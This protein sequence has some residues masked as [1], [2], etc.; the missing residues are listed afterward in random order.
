MHDSAFSQ[1]RDFILFNTT[2]LLQDDSGIPFH[3]FSTFKWKKYIFGEYTNPTIKVFQKNKQIDLA[4]YYATHEK[5]G[6]P[7]KMGYGHNQER[8][9]LLLAIP[10]R[11]ADKMPA[12]K[13]VEAVE[14]RGSSRKMP[15]FVAFAHGLMRKKGNSGCSCNKRA[16]SQELPPIPPVEERFLLPIP[17][18]TIGRFHWPNK[19]ARS[20]IQGGYGSVGLTN[21]SATRFRGP[22]RSTKQ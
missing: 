10:R 8:P 15:D 17:P 19:S 7:F 20:L 4:D 11:F 2:L 3:Y 1:I 22:P 21:H 13:V 12:I 6:I 16:R 5:I 14:S 9:N 18:D